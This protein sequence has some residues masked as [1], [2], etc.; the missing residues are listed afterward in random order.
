MGWAIRSALKGTAAEPIEFYTEFLD[1]AQF[2]D[3]SY[4]QSL[5][6]LLQNKYARQKIDLLIPMGDL[7]FHFLLAHREFLFPGVP[8]VSVGG[9]DR[10]AGAGQ[11]DGPYRELHRRRASARLPHPDQ[12]PL[13]MDLSSVD[14]GN[15]AT[16]RTVPESPQSVV[17]CW[18]MRKPFRSCCLRRR[19]SYQPSP[20]HCLFAIR[21]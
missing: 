18:D 8:M 15:D 14:E 12:A 17:I 16:P 5:I 13:I 2:P 19:R 21:Y 10:G 7:A 9:K 3:E 11:P 4:L 1:L 6:N 20:T